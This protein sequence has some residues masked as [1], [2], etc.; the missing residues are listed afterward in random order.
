LWPS[1]PIH[2]CSTKFQLS[3]AGQGLSSPFGGSTGPTALPAPGYP[4]LIALFFRIFG[5]FAVTAAI[6]VMASH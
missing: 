6:A 5:S 2:A 1:E 4:A 3:G